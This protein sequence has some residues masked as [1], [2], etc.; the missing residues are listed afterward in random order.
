MKHYNL[1]EFLS[2]FR[3]S[4]PPAQTQSPLLKTFWQRFWA[5]RQFVRLRI[6]SLLVQITL[7]SLMRIFLNEK[8]FLAF[9]SFLT[10]NL[11]K[12]IQT[13]TAS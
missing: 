2:I 3:M 11:Y 4:S 6:K 1:V 10:V 7:I 12:R 13:T 9:Q 8:S 5:Q